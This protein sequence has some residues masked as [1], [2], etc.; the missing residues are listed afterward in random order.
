L[1]ENLRAADV[2]VSPRRDAAAARALFTR[3]VTAGPVPVEATTDTAPAYPRVIDELM[4]RARHVTDRY[5]NHTVEADHGRL[6]ARLRPMRGLNTVRSSPTIAAGH[7]FVQNLRRGHYE[8][9]TE[10]PTRDRIH[11]CF[12]TSHSASNHLAEERASRSELNPRPPQTTQ[13]PYELSVD[14][15]A[16]DRVRVAFEELAPYL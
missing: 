11:A 10:H 1:E 16:R 9:P 8:L 5:A 13:Q 7:A 3:A 15:P 12:P 6:K 4:P 14:L 2:L